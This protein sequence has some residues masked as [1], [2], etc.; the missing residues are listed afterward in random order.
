MNPTGPQPPPDGTPR[1]VIDTDSHAQPAIYLTAD[2]PGIGGE[3]KQRPEDFLVDECPQYQPAGE[4]EH[5]YMLV[6]KKSLSTMEMVT[7]IARHFGVER[8]AV[9]YA[10]LKDKHAITRQVVSVHTPGRKPDDFPMLVH[11][12]IAVLWTD[13]HT[14]K[15]RRGHLRGNRFSVRIR[16]VRP[17]DVV[18][19]ARALKQLQASGVPNR[20]G[21]QRFGLLEN[22]HLIGRA[23]ALGDYAG[24]CD[25]LLSPSAAF[26]HVNEH[27]RA[28]YTQGLFEEARQAMPHSATAERRVLSRLAAGAPKRDAVRAIDPTLLSFYLSAFQSA[29]FNAVLDDRLRAGTLCTLVEG[30]IAGMLGRR[31]SFHVDSET[32]AAPE[33]LE[34]L[35]TFDISPTGPLWGPDMRRATGEVDAAEIRALERLG[36]GVDD[37]LRHKGKRLSLAGERRPLRVPLIDPEV[38]G[39]V[40]EHGAYVRMAFELPKGSFATVVA[41]EI[42]KRPMELPDAGEADTADSENGGAP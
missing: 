14:N 20:I 38:E 23:L 6:Q 18:H 32:A 34:R 41:A 36:I 16:G 11:E 19:A 30:D 37:L 31:S 12:Q 13:L 9:G 27:A 40:D 42:M 25:L 15:L 5:I 29:V 21:R 39:G 35:R 3:I 10:G 1:A 2:V 4:G 22:N 26:P 17:S 8:S 33:T 7:I 24:A 28:L